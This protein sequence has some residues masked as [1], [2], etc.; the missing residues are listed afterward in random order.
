VFHPKN[1][2][3]FLCVCSKMTTSS[4]HSSRGSRNDSDRQISQMIAFIKQEAREKAEEVEQK[5]EA[6]FQADKAV[7]IRN[8]SRGIRDDVER[9]K[10]DKT[11]LKK[12]EHSRRVTEA[13]T[14]RMLEREKIVKQV[15][16]EVLEKLAGVSKSQ[17]YP[18]LI[19][20]L[21]VQGLLT[22]AESHVTVQCRIEDVE[23]VKAQLEPA[24]KQ[25]HDFVKQ[26]TGVSCRTHLVLNQDEY[27]PS[28]KGEKTAQPGISCCGGVL[29]SARKGTIVCRN[30]LD[31]RL[32]LCYE[33]L[34]PLVRGMLFGVRPRPVNVVAP[35]SAHNA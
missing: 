22:I 11:V 10:K 7:R 35:Q 18:D 3:V 8:L 20:Y 13:R 33:H 21:L 26:E 2:F 23:I 19:R 6:E 32:D 12:I 5:T 4:P 34:I 30:T 31:S 24:V 28:G 25:Y 15:K 17:R 14:R 27:L 29:L 1:Y 16:E 9:K